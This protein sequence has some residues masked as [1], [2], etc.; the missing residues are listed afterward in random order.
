MS[1]AIK[2][3]SALSYSHKFQCK[4]QFIIGN[5]SP[6][7][8]STDKTVT[9]P[10]PSDPQLQCC[11]HNTHSLHEHYIYVYILNFSCQIGYLYPYIYQTCLSLHFVP[12]CIFSQS[13]FFYHIYCIIFHKWDSYH[14][15]GYDHNIHSCKFHLWIYF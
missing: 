3:L 14:C 7:K 11:H 6:C 5:L 1:P 8:F 12:V 9:G 13:G 15:H 2:Y 4:F 10:A